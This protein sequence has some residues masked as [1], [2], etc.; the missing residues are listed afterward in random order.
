MKRTAVFLSLVAIAGCRSTVENALGSPTGNYSLV[1]VDGSAIPFKAGTSLTVRGTI[2]L[3]SSGDYSLTQADSATTGAVANTSS[4][5]QWSLND[6]ALALLSS[7]TIELG[8]VMIDSI[9]LG[10]AGHQNLYVRH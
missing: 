9:R 6:N 1:S 5:G 8:I 7:G 10:H 4:S 2:S 3:K